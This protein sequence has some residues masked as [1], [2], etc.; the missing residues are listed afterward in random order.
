M[1]VTFIQSLSFKYGG[2]QSYSTVY[3]SYIFKYYLIKYLVIVYSSVDL[4][5]KGYQVIYVE[6][7]LLLSTI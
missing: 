6:C 5:V 1:G 2:L 4:W 7:E 3:S